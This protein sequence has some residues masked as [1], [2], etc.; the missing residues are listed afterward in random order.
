M[1]VSDNSLLTHV[2][3]LKG[4]NLTLEP[5][6]VCRRHLTCV[7]PGTKDDYRDVEELLYQNTSKIAIIQEQEVGNGKRKRG[8]VISE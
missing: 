8:R 7:L 5:H 4:E 3:H 2:L 6:Q 1:K